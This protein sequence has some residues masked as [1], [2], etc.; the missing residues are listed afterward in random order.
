M[1][2]QINNDEWIDVQFND[3]DWQDVEPSKNPEGVYQLSASKYFKPEGVKSFR[4][5]HP[6]LSKVPNSFPIVGAILG[7]L[8]GAPTGGLASAGLAGIGAMGGEELKQIV[9]GLTGQRKKANWG[10][11][12]KE[13]L[14][15]AGGELGGQFVGRGFEAMQPAIAETLAGVPKKDYLRVLEN[16]KSGKGIFKRGAIDE[17][18]EGVNAI[19]KSA[20]I[21][22]AISIPELTESINDV[23]NKFGGININP[24]KEN[25][26]PELK[27]LFEQIESSRMASGNYSPENAQLM[28]SLIKD[29]GKDAAENIMGRIG[30]EV[31]EQGD[32]AN[33]YDIHKIKQ[34]IGSKIGD[35]EKYK[36]SEEQALKGIYGA[37][38]EALNKAHPEYNL[39]NEAYRDALAEAQ[40]KGVLP[41]YAGM[42]L[43]KNAI[44]ANLGLGASMLGTGALFGATHNPLTF[45]PELGLVSQM[46][47]IMQRNILKIYGGLMKSKTGGGG[48]ALLEGILSPE[49]TEKSNY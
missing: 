29:Y 21:E 33:F 16:L 23:V 22:Q 15:G 14:F 7:G 37:I 36:G 8:A 27:T 39:A 31:G 25:L 44:K 45:L 19:A 12:G 4:E 26:S 20:G 6:I 1:A 11:V 5:A 40:F 2:N 3:N 49:K 38:N 48:G 24:T 18:K 30:K 32:L 17:A 42:Y 43:G 47:P 34:D 9:E 46:S 41:R 13:G 10:E 28:D 35:F